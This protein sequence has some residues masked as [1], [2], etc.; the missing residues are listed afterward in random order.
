MTAAYPSRDQ[1]QFIADHV[2]ALIAHVD[3]QF[4]YLFA[5]KAYAARFGLTPDEVVGKTIP[6][7][8]GIEA[9]EAIRPHAEACFAGRESSWEADIPYKD[10]GVRHVRV[11]YTP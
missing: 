8:V 9:F 11:L 5:N 2:P 3:R 10:I 7:V 4:R 1:L 6:Q